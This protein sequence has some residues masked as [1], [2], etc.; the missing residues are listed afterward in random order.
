MVER[1]RPHELAVHPLDRRVVAAQAHLAAEPR[2]LAELLVGQPH[3][4]LLVY[5]RHLVEV[6]RLHARGKLDHL[7][8]AEL[9][10][11]GLPVEDEGGADQHHDEK[12]PRQR[13]QELG[14]AGE[15]LVWHIVERPLAAV[16]EL[17]GQLPEM[18]ERPR[19]DI[20]G[21]DHRPEEGA[22]RI[23][24]GVEIGRLKK[25]IEADAKG[26]DKVGNQL[27]PFDLHSQSSLSMPHFV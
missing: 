8:G 4:Q 2:A 12:H 25:D 27:V 26:N 18:H 24:E 7:G 17:E 15:L 19:A 3:G 9:V 6:D 20:E 1:H 5:D 13:K 14:P 16:G 21:D 22:V 23:E 11:E 10:A